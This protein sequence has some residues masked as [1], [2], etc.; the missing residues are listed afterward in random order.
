MQLLSSPARA[1][2]SSDRPFARSAGRRTAPFRLVGL[3]LLS[4]GLVGLSAVGC[5]PESQQPSAEA[6]PAPEVSVEER[7]ASVRAALDEFYAAATEQDWQ[8]IGG[9]LAPD[10]ELYTDGAESFDR[11][12]YLGLLEQES[13]EV[14]EMRLDDVQIDVVGDLGVATFKGFFDHGNG[15]TV[16]TAETTVFR[17]DG[18]AWLMTHAHASVKILGG[19]EAHAE[20]SD[21]AETAG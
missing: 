2:Q 12:T 19:E 6:A 11:E 5:A 1:P 20:G 7:Q 16:D 18:T 4:L 8:R 9:M 17:H 13:L 21:A 14:A 10:F 3:G 15:M